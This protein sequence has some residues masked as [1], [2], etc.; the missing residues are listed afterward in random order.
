MKL[1]AQSLTPRKA[2]LALSLLLVLGGAWL[3]GAELAKLTAHDGGS[4]DRF[5]QAVAMTA[6]Y[7]VVGAHGEDTGGSGAGAVYVYNRSTRAYLYTLTASDAGPNHQFGWSLAAQGASLLVGAPGNGGGACYLFNLATGTE[8]GKLLPSDPAAG[9]QFGYSVA[10]SAN[11]LLVGAWL[12]EDDD[13]N[14]SQNSGAAYLYGRPSLAQVRRLRSADIAPADQFGG[15][16]ALSNGLACVGSLF[17]DHSGKVDAGAVY[18]FS[19][20]SGGQLQK[21]ISHSPNE[22]DVF[23]AAIAAR[24]GRLVVGAPEADTQG[25][26][27][28]AAFLYGL[29]SGSHLTDLTPSGGQAGDRIG[30]SVALGEQIGVGAYRSDLSGVSD[31]GSV[32]SFS[33]V[34]GYLATLQSSDAAGSDFL[35]YSVAA[36]GEE[37]LAGA[38]QDDDGGPSSGSAYLFS[39]N[40]PPVLGEV[41]LTLSGHDCMLSWQGTVG[42]SYRVFTTT[43]LESWPSEPLATLA[44]SGSVVAF[45]HSGGAIDRVRFYRVVAG[46]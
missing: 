19:V 32:H 18:L 12:A 5:G 44:A 37:C 4:F 41:A 21:V 20:S 30:C 39:M 46:D 16:V 38:L 29:P 3:P 34:G 33:L 25:V 36:D 27:S 26:S 9:D 45:T 7:L 35:G 24:D 11:H 2:S 22:G 43:S 1:F 17:N 15:S 23:G 13:N 42:A 10:I 31:S 28:G 14:P 8:L 6:D 40:Q